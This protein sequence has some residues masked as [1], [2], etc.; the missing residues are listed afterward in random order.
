MLRRYHLRLLQIHI[1]LR[2]YL[3]GSGLD[4]RQ[5]RQRQR[6]GI[7]LILQSPQRPV[8]IHR[9]PPDIILRGIEKEMK[10][11]VDFNQR[12]C[13]LRTHEIG[14]IAI[15]KIHFEAE[16]SAMQLPL[17]FHGNRIRKYRRQRQ[18]LSFLTR[19]RDSD[20]VGD[21]IPISP[22][23]CLP[24]HLEHRKLCLYIPPRPAIAFA[25]KEIAFVLT[26]PVRRHT[27]NLH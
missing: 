14:T 8:A 27:H 19:K 2:F 16:I 13:D 7:A 23:L 17:R 4:F 5:M 26:S 11:S 3:G 24:F 10:T 15:F 21:E 1:E 12:A 22:R 25:A 9:C 20:A 6:F 18:K